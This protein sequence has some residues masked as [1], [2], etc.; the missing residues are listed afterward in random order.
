MRLEDLPPGKL[1]RAAIA[2]IAAEEDQ[3]A[4][5]SES[6]PIARP[7]RRSTPPSPDRAPARASNPKRYRCATCG[8][9][10]ADLAPAERDADAHGGARIELDPGGL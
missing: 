2:A 1:R 8:A 9:F 4:R 6:S 3:R 5:G 7:R 10:H